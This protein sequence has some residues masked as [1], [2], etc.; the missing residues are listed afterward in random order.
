MCKSP[1]FS[2]STVCLSEYISKILNKFRG[3]N[4]LKKFCGLIGLNMSCQD[5]ENII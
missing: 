5:G 4:I 2:C 3:G 1:S